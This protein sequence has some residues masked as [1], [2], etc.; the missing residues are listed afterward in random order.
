MANTNII[1]SPVFVLCVCMVNHTSAAVYAYTILLIFL[2]NYDHVS[3]LHILLVLVHVNQLQRLILWTF[4]FLL[5][6][7]NFGIILGYHSMSNIQ[8]RL[9]NKTT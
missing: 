8:S 3:Y 7:N 6:A 9:E 5:Y 1:F 2:I 4:L